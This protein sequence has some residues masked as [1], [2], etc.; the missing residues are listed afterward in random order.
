[1]FRKAARIAVGMLLAASVYAPAASASDRLYIRIQPPARIVSDRNHH[2]HRGYVWRSG[3]YRWD[4]HRYYWV[5]GSWGRPPY[6]HAVWVSGRW[7][8]ERRG[9]YWVPGHWVRA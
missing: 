5:R 2:H 1:M 3:Y 4:G 7:M 9:W 8:H 6:R